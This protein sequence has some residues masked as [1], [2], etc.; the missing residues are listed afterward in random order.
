MNTCRSRPASVL[1]FVDTSSHSTGIE[2]M[3][4]ES[5]MPS[6]KMISKRR[7]WE[8]RGDVCTHTFE[9]KCIFLC[10]VSTGNLT[11]VLACANEHHSW[12]VVDCN[13]CLS[14][15]LYLTHA[16]VRRWPW[17]CWW[18]VE[19]KKERFIDF[20]CEIKDKDLAELISSFVVDSY[21]REWQIRRKR[22]KEINRKVWLSPRCS[23]PRS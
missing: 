8:R 16:R 10:H 15:Y 13:E 14:I 6:E 9:Y 20:K 11:H 23:N 2:A 5:T 4:G 22:S 17:C 19:G 18:L 7:C 3:P 12:L 21:V 1:R